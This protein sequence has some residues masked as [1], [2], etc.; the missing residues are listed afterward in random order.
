MRG[1]DKTILETGKMEIPRFDLTGKV[2]I[3]TGAGSPIGIGRGIARTFAAY[4]ASLV[5]ADVDEAEI[6]ERAEEI[7]QESGQK[8]IGVRC[9]V[10]NE[11]DRAH[12]VQTT[13]DEFGQIDILVNNAGV[14]LSDDQLAVYVDEEEWDR[15]V[16]TDYK[17][18]FF[19][20]QR[21]ANIMIEQERGN[22]I[23]IASVVARIAST[24]MLPYASAKAA[25]LQMT[26]CMAFE[27][28][29]FNIRANCICPG[30]IETNMTQGTLH[31]EKAYEA[32]TR[33]IPHNRKVG[34]PLDVA[35]AALFLACDCS[36]MVN[37]T[38]IYVDGARS[39]W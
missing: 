24:R 6:L 39:I 33:P 34:D 28:A 38:P 12:L 32:I 21:V 14:A 13:M 30:Y 9:D 17:G 31:K 19:L 11:E 3:I 8:V 23:N 22:I 15:V 29:R 20:T 1:S 35:A 27:W 36:D 26:R 5:L 4:G 18:V 7:A 25:V 37:G 10:R 16:D 2:A